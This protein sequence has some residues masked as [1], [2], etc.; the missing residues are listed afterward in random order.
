LQKVK[1]ENESEFPEIEFIIDR[2]NV[3]STE[4][5]GLQEKQLRLAAE[6]EQLRSA[7]QQYSKDQ[8]NLNLALNNDIAS[9]LLCAARFSRILLAPLI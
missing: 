8:M 4:Q 2:Y 1:D 3:L 6:S 9:T 7:F 5:R